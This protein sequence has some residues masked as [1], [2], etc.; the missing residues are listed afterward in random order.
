MVLEATKEVG[1]RGPKAASKPIID[2]PMAGLGIDRPEEPREA[3]V[4]A[5]DSIAPGE[6]R[7]ARALA[8]AAADDQRPIEGTAKMPPA[9]VERGSSGGL[10][11]EAEALGGSCSRREPRARQS[12]TG[13][14]CICFVAI[15]IPDLGIRFLPGFA[16]Q[17]ATGLTS[18]FGS[19]C[20][21][22]VQPAMHIAAR[23]N[24]CFTGKRM[25]SSN[26]GKRQKAKCR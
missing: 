18:A 19:G 13:L 23:Q 14:V 10:A 24:V 3:T 20:C 21:W 16:G 11:S 7:V 17:I 4:R 22:S 9:T 8:G 5:L 6:E 26:L 2:V 1:S 12:E 25:E 15:S